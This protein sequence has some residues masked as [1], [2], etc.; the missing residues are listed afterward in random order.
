MKKL[1]ISIDVGGTNSRLKCEIVENEKVISTSREYSKIVGS[2]AALGKFIQASI[3]NFSDLK[4][5]KCVAGFAGAII[6]RKEVAITNW[7]D[8]PV[9]SL[10]DMF[11][12]G[13]P[14]NTFMVN[15]MELASYGLLD[16]RDN[17]LIPSEICKVL[18]MPEDL[19]RKYAD[20]M[21]LIAPGTGFG[22]GSIVEVKTKSKE[23]IYEVISSEIQH[24]QIPPL[25]ETHEKMIQ[26]IFGKKEN[27]NFLNYE[28]FVSGQG[29]EDSYSA[30]LR[31][32]GRKPSEK[33][34]GEIAQSALNKTDETA[35]KA[36]DYFYRI[37]GRLVQ[38]MSLMV[39][40]YGGVFLCGANTEKNADF[41]PNS[42]FLYEMHNCLV[43][44]QLLEQ[45]PVYIVAKPDINIAGGLW[46]CRN[47]I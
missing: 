30:L 36:L 8:R 13:L 26:L 17:D 47:V 21:L 46:A 35:M 33:N 2:K 9:I 15:D 39:Q 22:T 31:L 37:T 38:A 27:R 6:D 32:N 4:P 20:N 41:I 7:Q 10:N 42:G 18:Y 14:E 1:N 40:P 44:K 16:M 25:D 34:A 43:R 45:Y 11:Q 3:K 5:D 23:R 12:W 19:S 29:L 28:D 24:I